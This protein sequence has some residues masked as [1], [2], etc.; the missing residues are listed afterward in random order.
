MSVREV[1]WGRTTGGLVLCFA[2]LH[3]PIL[4]WGLK[5][6]NRRALTS[7][8]LKLIT[9]QGSEERYCPDAGLKS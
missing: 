7:A 3:L 4:L 5:R 1:G 2:L 8:S 6:R 9:E